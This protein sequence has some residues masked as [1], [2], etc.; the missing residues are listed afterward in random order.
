[1]FHL[2][3]ITQVNKA[4]IFNSFKHKIKSTL[5]LHNCVYRDSLAD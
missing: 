1:M 3:F 5:I 2:E 4:S